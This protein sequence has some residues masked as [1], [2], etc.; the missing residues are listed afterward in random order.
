MWAPLAAAIT[1]MLR[2][3]LD[4]SL[5]RRAF[6][7]AAMLLPVAM[8]L[9]L[10]FAFFGGIGGTYA[11]EGYTPLADFLKLN[12]YKLT[13]VHYLFITHQAGSNGEL[14]S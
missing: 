13:H 14:R 4:E 6:T 2:P 9:G 7:A 10:R 11:T 1:I 5:R 3:K 12:F 8:W